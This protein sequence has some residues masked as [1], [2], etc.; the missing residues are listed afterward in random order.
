MTQQYSLAH[1][2][3]LDC[4][5]P[6]MTYL[7]ARAGYDFVSFRLIPIG[8]PGEPSYVPQDKQ[9]LRRT[10]RALTETGLG[11]LDLELARIV[12]DL[13]A[14]KY[15]PAMEAAAELGA[16]HVISSAWTTR[17]DDKSFLIDCFA[18]LCDMARALGLTMNFEFPTFSRVGDLRQA[19]DI[20]ASADRDNGGILID[21]LYMHF[22]GI[23]LEQLDALPRHWFRFVHLCDAPL[24]V[25]A[26][27]EGQIQIARGARLYPG[28]GAIDITGIL[29]R[30][31]PVP[32]SIELP[33][34][35]RARELGFEEHA[36]R[37]LQTARSRIE[38]AVAPD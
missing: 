21:M 19:A 35:A 17:Q 6:E 32:I 38:A 3:V 18:A 24:A 5:P 2:T 37:C 12:D 9:L 30:L 34:A 28:E 8:L 33:H 29:N 15:L 4:A 13:D 31:P 22:G 25:P 1:L 36:R 11:L 27:R 26:T 20:V 10:K 23:R 7:A 14:A 16:K